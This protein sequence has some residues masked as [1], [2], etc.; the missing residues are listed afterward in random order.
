MEKITSGS[1]NQHK[2]LIP[3]KEDVEKLGGHGRDLCRKVV[4]LDY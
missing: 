2:V 4:R 3:L 1:Q